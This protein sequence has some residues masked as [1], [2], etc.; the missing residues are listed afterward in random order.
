MFVVPALAGIRAKNRLKAG[1]Q[2]DISSR[3]QYNYSPDQSATLA[4]NV[5]L[6]RWTA[7]SGEMP[8]C[9][10]I[11]AAVGDWLVTVTAAVPPVV[12]SSEPAKTAVIAASC[13]AGSIRSAPVSGLDL[14][15]TTV[16][17]KSWTAAG[18]T[19]LPAVIVKLYV[20][21]L[22][23]ADIPPRVAVPFFPALKVTPLGNVPVSLSM[24]VVG[25]PAVVLIVKLP[26]AP[27]VKVVLA[28]L[29]MAGVWST[30]SVNACVVTLDRPLPAVIVK[31]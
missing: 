26:N 12:S 20:P 4:N 2:R 8:S 23:A 5:L 29:V 21:T 17:V 28:A 13:V 24:V 6:A 7:D 19:P 1:L 27:T 15:A 10:E 25:N 22:P 16:N 9:G 11:A 18:D 31:L 3:A 30:V 14:A